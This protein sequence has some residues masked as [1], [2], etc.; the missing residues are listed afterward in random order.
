MCVFSMGENL[1]ISSSHENALSYVFYQTESVH[2]NSR[3]ATLQR[4]NYLIISRYIAREIAQSMLAVMVIL[5]LI[6]VSNYFVR[7]LA[8]VDSGLLQVKVIVFMLSLNTITALSILLPLALFLAV[9][10]AFGR[11][12]KDNEIVAME[13]CGVSPRAGVQ[14][15]TVYAVLI[16]IVVAVL[17][18][19]IAPWA[20]ER[21]YQIRDEQKASSELAGLVS[22]RFIEPRNVQGVIYVEK[23]EINDLSIEQKTLHN[24]FIQ[25]QMAGQAGRQ[26]LLTAEKGR[27]RRDPVSGDSYLVLENGSRYEGTPGDRDYSII[28]FRRHSVRLNEP[29]LHHSYR[30]HR[31]RSSVSLLAMK[32]SADVA[33]LQWRLSMPLSAL[34][35]AFLAVPLSRT[36]PR[37]GKYAKLFIAIL[38][39]VV[40]SNL[41]GMAQTWVEQGVVPGV[42]GMW[43][44]HLLLVVMI[45][46]L[47]ARQYGHSWLLRTLYLKKT[48]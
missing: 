32:K 12:Y 22:G 17:S 3:H 37:Q 7:I 5:L 29:V 48:V 14:A 15:V 10:L 18:L 23:I 21:I 20:E 28:E 8:D 46:W 44:V 2:E 43:W 19:W 40:Y 26:V 34:L 1:F 36:G 9:L 35:L 11:L 4:E 30:R 6:Y 27:Q 41:L 24:I 31:A 39:Y 47:L 42:V 33:E 38:I 25:S 13:A 16:A 45:W